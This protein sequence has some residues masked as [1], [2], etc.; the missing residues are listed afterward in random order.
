MSLRSLVV[1]YGSI[2]KRH[3]RILRSMGADTAVVSSR[4]IDHNP[5]FHTLSEAL[6]QFQ[7]EYVVVANRTSEHLAT[8]QEL[9]NQSFRGV[10]MIEKPIYMHPAAVDLSTF[11]GVFVAYNLR[12]HPVIRTLKAELA[13]A[14]AVSVHAYVGKYLPQWRPGSDYR[15]SYSARIKHGG[16]VLRDLSHELDY[17]TWLFGSWKHLSALGGKFSELEIESADAFGL[18]LELE[19]AKMVTLQLNYLDRLGCREII[20]NTKNETFRADLLGNTLTS[21]K[22]RQTF[23][24]EPDDTYRL[25]HEAVFLGN[26]ENLCSVEEGL[27]T[28]RLIEAAERS[29]ARKEAVLA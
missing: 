27:G 3:A 26:S 21:S 2:G 10:V 15:Q 19:R 20:I 9:A 18:L 12:F 7:P 22:G 1:G 17:L 13:G 14:E 29:S 8:L 11:K 4:Q 28:A 16:G 25:E 5:C 6:A 24:V 23:P